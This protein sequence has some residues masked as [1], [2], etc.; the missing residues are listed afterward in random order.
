MIQIKLKNIKNRPGVFITVFNKKGEAVSFYY[1][2]IINMEMFIEVI[3]TINECIK[4]L[5]EDKCKNM[6]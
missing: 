4:M 2:K 5:K 3:K 1:D 6:L